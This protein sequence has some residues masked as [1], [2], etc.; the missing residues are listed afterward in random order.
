[1][2]CEDCEKVWD[3]GIVVPHRWKNATVGI[4]ACRKHAKEIIDFL[5]KRIEVE[6]VDER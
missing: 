2:G 4:I 5:N 1:M 3:S 6:E